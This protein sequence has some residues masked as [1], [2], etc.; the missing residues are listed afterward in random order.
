MVGSKFGVR[1]GIG[2]DRTPAKLVTRLGETAAGPELGA[3]IIGRRVGELSKSAG[4]KETIIGGSTDTIIEDVASMTAREFVEGR[5]V[6]AAIDEEVGAE[7]IGIPDA[8]EI[9]IM[10]CASDEIKAGELVLEP[11]GALLT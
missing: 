5:G 2:S 1:T 7:I 11:R 9:E 8:L 6:G 4:A 10:G 3:V